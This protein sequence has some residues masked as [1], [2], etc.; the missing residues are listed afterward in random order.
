MAGNT[1]RVGG[2]VIGIGVIGAGYWGPKHVRNFAALGA[3]MGWVADL[4][5]ARLASV[6]AEYPQLRTTTDFRELLAQ[7]EVNAVV[8]ATPVSTHAAVAAAALRAGKHVLVE[9]PL[10]LSSADATE[11]IE[12]AERRGLVLMVGHT[13]LFN[14]AVHCLR[15]LVESGELGEIYYAHAQRLNLGLFQRDINVVWDLA[16]HDIS[17]LMHVLGMPPT[18]ASVQGHGYVRRH[19]EDV[20]QLNITFGERVGALIHV[21]WLDPNKVRRITIVGSRKMVVYDDI[22]PL[23]KIRIYDKGVEPPP[24]S[25]FGEFQLSYRYGSITIPHLRSTEP[26]RAEC[27]HFLHCIETG[28]TPTTD[29]RQGLSVVRVLEAL[30]ASLRDGGG[31]YPVNGPL[32]KNGHAKFMD[33]PTSP[34]SVGDRHTHRAV[35][36]SRAT[37]FPGARVVP[38]S[39]ASVPDQSERNGR[40]VRTES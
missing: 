36:E 1:S 35:P 18:A 30:D 10:A 26:L 33:R 27:Q 19:V 38:S 8:V 32:F 6:H 21:S 40:A 24:V 22:E 39:M 20:A 37:E 29:G 14:P 23:E 17:I 5:P 7:T 11:L 31:I 3:G 12:L 34:L 25:G 4:D 16:P 13:F 9:K 2:K 15:E 28:Q